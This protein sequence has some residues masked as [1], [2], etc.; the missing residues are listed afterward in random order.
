MAFSFR[1]RI[2]RSNG[3]VIVKIDEQE[4]EL[5]EHLLPQLRDVLVGVAPSGELDPAIVRLFP[6]AHPEDVE[7]EAAYQET[8]RDRLLAAR[9][10]RL[11]T[12]EATLQEESLDD[13][14]H[15]AWIA[16]IND[17]RLVLGTRLDVGEEDEPLDFESDDPAT[18]ALATYHYLGH[19][20]GELVE[21]VDAGPF[22][23]D[24]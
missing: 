21:A 20:L 5:L 24:R 10:D 4:R 17:M 6:T 3:R 9:L 19:L 23:P 22:D 14:Q 2:R 1:R 13:E 15:A 18:A 7:A 8:Q 16:T 11:D 12:V